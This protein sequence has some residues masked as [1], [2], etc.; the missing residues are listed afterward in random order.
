[1]ER[2]GTYFKGDRTIW[3]VVIILS[4]FSVLAVYSS[5]GTLAYK[6]QQGNTEYYLFKHFAI[7]F[8]G[9]LLMYFAHNV[10]YTYYSRVSQILIWIAV[11]LLMI[12]LFMGTTL[13]QAPRW[14]TL[15]VVGITFQTSDLAKLA[16]IMFVAR[17]LSKK[18][19]Q[20]KDLKSAF[21]PIIFPVL[22][23][24]GLI[25]PANLSTAAVLFMTC[26][27]LMFIGRVNFKYLLALMGIGLLGLGLTIML[28]MLTPHQGRLV[29]WKHRIENYVSGD[30]EGNYQV[31]QSKIAIA[32]GGWF[33]VG[34][35]NSTQRN[36]L[37]H[38]YSDFIFAI[39]IEE[40]GLLGATVIILLYLILLFR[41]IRIVA[42]SPGAFG[43][44]LAMG[45]C[46]SLVFQAMIN[47]A[48]AVNLF[49]VT[50]LALPL[51]SMGGTSI[52]FT[53]IALGIILSV[54]KSTKLEEAGATSGRRKLS[55]A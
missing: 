29:T 52:L 48:V 32:R 43:T 33:G 28:L 17:L 11:P 53:S 15:P 14:L 22:L 6:Y 4:I 19:N 41:T 54:S 1:M 13:N 47:M 42:K 35:G 12:T 51:V 36:F 37:P 38:P 16:L 46:F 25:L 20:I 7:L 18:Q 31:E 24:C 49:P 50:G 39:I 3:I 45:C 55:F 27:C 44:L 2:L 34:P 9:I 21:L 8:A 5:T 10:K 30:N 23:V 40:Y 26:I